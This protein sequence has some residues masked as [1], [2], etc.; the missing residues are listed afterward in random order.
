[1]EKGAFSGAI[2]RKIGR[3]ELAGNG[4]LFLDEIGDMS[5]SMQSK[6]LRVLQERTLERVGGT[7]PISV[8]CRLIAATNK[9]IAEL[10]SRGVFRED[11]YYRLSTVTLKLPPLRERTRDIPALA[12][13]FVEEANLAYGRSVREIPER[14]MKSLMTHPWPGNIRQLKNVIA[15]AVILSDGEEISGLELGDTRGPEED[16]SIDK[17]LPTTVRHYATAIEKKIIRSVLDQNG[18][19]I[20]RTAARLGISRKTLYDKIRRHEL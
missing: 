2:A 12:R 14:V 1:H 11:L 8:Y 20:S 15:N 9:D 19:N 7:K 3:F 13:L 6:L 4:T 16:V 18:G 17:D 10:R 5:L